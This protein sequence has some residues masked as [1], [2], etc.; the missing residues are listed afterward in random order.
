MN[1]PDDSLA[2]HN[3]YTHSDAYTQAEVFEQLLAGKDFRLQRI[4]SGGQS[5]PEGEWYDQDD[6]EWVLLLS[7]HARLRFEAS[8]EVRELY[9]GDYIHIPAHCRHR[10]EYTALDAPSVWLAVQY[11]EIEEQ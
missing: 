6:H 9:P 4:I 7:G 3:F 10:V 1:K 5:T 11:C 8:D 2:V